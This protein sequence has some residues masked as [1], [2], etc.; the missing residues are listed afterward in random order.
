MPTYKTPDVYVEE[1]SVFPPSV[2]EVETAIPAFIGYTEKAIRNAPNDLQLKPTKIYSLKDYENYYGYPKE[3]TLNIVVVS[4]G[5]GGLKVD[6]FQAPTLN[7]LMYYSIKMFFDNGG[8]QCYIISVGSYP[9]ASDTITKPQLSALTKGLDALALEDEP[10]L[11]I[12]PEAVK[13]YPQTDYQTLVQAVLLQCNK[14]GDRFAIFDLYN[15]DQNLNETPSGSS[16][17]YLLSNREYFGNNYLKYGAAYYPFL[18]TTM[19][20]YVN[21]SGV[22]SITVTSGG[23]GYNSDT[24]V[25]FTGGGGTVKPMF[26]L[27]LH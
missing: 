25:S 17:T 6:S 27:N 3:D 23:T 4:D 7:Y 14:L 9:S 5:A 21:D 11:I 18:K 12:I 2:A 1:I 8:G 26:R 16:Q 20:F 15:G 19:N 24:T 22:A 13:L 10:T